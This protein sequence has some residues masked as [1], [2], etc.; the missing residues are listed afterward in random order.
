[1]KVIAEEDT[2]G[3]MSSEISSRQEAL[4]TENEESNSK[5]SDQLNT[6]PTFLNEDKQMIVNIDVTKNDFKSETQE[7]PLFMTNLI[8]ENPMTIQITPNNMKNPGIFELKKS[9]AHI[10]SQEDQI[11][12]TT[13]SPYKQIFDPHMVSQSIATNPTPREMA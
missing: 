12:M 13:P 3:K 1:M 5:K 6:E 8:S 11:I 10:S 7:N 2:E 4:T 9:Y